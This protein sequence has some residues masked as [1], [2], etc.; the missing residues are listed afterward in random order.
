MSERRQGGGTIVDA[1]LAVPEGPFSERSVAEV[2]T[3]KV[4]VAAAP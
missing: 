1:R 3:H 2:K 4:L